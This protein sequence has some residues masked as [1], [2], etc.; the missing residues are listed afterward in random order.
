MF[1]NNNNNEAFAKNT[2]AWNKTLILIFKLIM[3]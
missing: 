2:L 1:D 3:Y